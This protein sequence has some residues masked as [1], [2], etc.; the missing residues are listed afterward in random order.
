MEV[1]K[2][3]VPSFL[4]ILP[5]LFEEAMNFL[6]DLGRSIEGRVDRDPLCPE[7]EEHPIQRGEEVRHPRVNLSRYEEILKRS[8]GDNCAFVQKDHSVEEMGEVRG[9]VRQDDKGFP[10]SVEGFNVVYEFTAIRWIQPSAWFIE[11]Q[12]IRVRD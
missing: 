4:W 2:I 11:D 12:D 3:P 10:P 7:V 9:S 1:P 6:G 8:L 5:L